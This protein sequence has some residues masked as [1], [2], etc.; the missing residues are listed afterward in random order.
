MHKLSMS[1]C[2]IS[3]FLDWCLGFEPTIRLKCKNLRPLQNETH[4]RA[5]IL[6]TGI[7]AVTRPFQEQSVIHGGMLSR[8]QKGYHFPLHRRL[9]MKW[10]KGWALFLEEEGSR[11][12]ANSHLVWAL[13]HMHGYNRAGWHRWMLILYI[14]N[15]MA[16]V[17]RL[18]F[19]S[20]IKAGNYMCNG[21]G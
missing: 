9:I 21:L 4:M 20:S 6:T 7:E 8:K 11:V 1:L 2:F 18:L 16:M 3:I 5:S 12:E 13:I 17:V 14:T 10:R 15:N 19:H